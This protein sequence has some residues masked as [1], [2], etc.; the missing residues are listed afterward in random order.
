M[1]ITLGLMT[2]FF[3]VVFVKYANV[4]RR[5]SLSDFYVVVVSMKWAVYAHAEA[6]EISRATFF[7]VF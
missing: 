1:E 2:S 6:G 3:L 4:R 7:F 5:L